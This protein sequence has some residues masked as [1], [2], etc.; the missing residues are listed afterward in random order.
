MIPAAAV[1]L[2]Q[3]RAEDGSTAPVVR[4][5]RW[6]DLPATSPRTWVGPTPHGSTSRLLAHAVGREVALLRLRGRRARGSTVTIHRLPGRGGRVRSTAAGSAIAEIGG[7]RGPTMLDEILAAAGFEGPATALRPVAG[8]GVITR[9]PNDGVLLRVA[10]RAAPAAADRGRPPS[11]GALA[12]LAPRPRGNGELDGLRWS[13]ETLLPGRPPRRL[14]PGLVAAVAGVLADVP[15]TPAP[16]VVGR[17][18]AE[19]AATLAGRAERL[20]A[21]AEAVSPVVA[22]QPG[23]TR[24][25]DLWHGNLLVRRGRLTGI[26]DWDASDPGG[27]PGADLLQLVVT[28]DRH[29]RRLPLGRAWLERPWL[30]DAWR[31]ATAPYWDRS[32]VRPDEE[33]L[34]LAAVSWWVAEVAGTLR[35]HP[36]RAGD[37]AWL[38]TN[39]DAV[40]AV[41]A[42]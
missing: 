13:A 19:V 35:R 10:D 32:A 20:A 28:A 38:A 1:A 17:E 33:L 31:R 25:G 9:L 5:S 26:V 7:G 2:V 41:L 22:R 11:L 4:A 3:Q 15:P 14:T 37:E 42:R 27:V 30:Q 36:H 29:R 34:H 16:T 8:G 40:L 18:L 21:V 24:H 23:T 6:S 39:V 12:Q